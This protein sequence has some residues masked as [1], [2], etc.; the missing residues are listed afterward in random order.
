MTIDY[1]SVRVPPDIAGAVALL[2]SEKGQFV[3]VDAGLD[4]DWRSRLSVIRLKLS[5][6]TRCVL[7]QLFGDYVIGVDQLDLSRGGIYGFCGYGIDSPPRLANLL[8]DQHYTYL[9]GVW[10]EYI[11]ACQREA[12]LQRCSAEAT[13][14]AGVAGFDK[15]L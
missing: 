13:E 9:T 4:P 12:A 14:G 6:C 11:A 3:M 5:S 8:H 10:V 2:D 1:S 7:G 15:D